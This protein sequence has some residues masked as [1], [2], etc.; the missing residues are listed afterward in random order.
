MPLDLLLVT[1]ISRRHREQL[2][3]AGFRVHRAE[4]DERRREVIAEHGDSIRAVLTIGTIGFTAEEMDELPRLG[5]ICAQGVG[6]EGIDVAAARERGIAVTHGPGTNADTV[7]DHTLGLMLACLRRIPQSDAAVRRGEWQNARRSHPDLHGRTLGLLGMGNIARAIAKRAHYGF[8][9]PVVYHSRSPKTE[10]P[11]HHEPEARR[12]AEQA[13]VLVA[14][15]PGGPQTHHLV[16]EAMLTALGASGVLINI[17]RGS[18]VDTEA[19]VAAIRERRIASAGL[20]VIDGEPEVP[21][22][23]LAE[24]SIILTPHTAGLSPSALEATIA[25]VIR[26]LQAFEAGEALVTPVP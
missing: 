6:F 7:A 13:D 8:D 12:V 10:L 24:E 21:E 5:L 15:L 16:D 17:G 22:D 20:D 2:T 18:V 23:V 11:Y 9:M 25:L 14:A 26:N 19:L 4:H 3:Q 1:H